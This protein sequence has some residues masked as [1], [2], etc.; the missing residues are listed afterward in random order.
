M[1]DRRGTAGRVLGFAIAMTSLGSLAGGQICQSWARTWGGSGDEWTFGL[2]IDSQGNFYLPGGTDSVGAGG[3]DALLLE[4]DSSGSFGW[5][6]TWGGSG[7]DDMQG[8]FFDSR[9]GGGFILSGSTR[10]FGASNEDVMLLKFD[11][12]GNLQWARTWDSLGNDHADAVFEDSAG[13]LYLAG[14]STGWSPFFQTEV[15]LMK[16]AAGS[17]PP[18]NPSVVTWGASSG[19]A[20]INDGCVWVDGSSGIEYVYV[21]GNLW[22]PGNDYDVLLQKYDASLNL[23]WSRSW[24]GSLDDDCWGI[25]VDGTGD[26]YV[27]GTTSSYS[28]G[29]EDALLLRWDA[30]GNLLSG[31][32]WGGP[33]DDGTGAIF[34]SGGY[35]YLSAKT[36]S[37]DPGYSDGLFLKYDPATARFLW[38]KTWGGTGQDDG[39]GLLPWNGSFWGVGFTGIHPGF[40]RDCIGTVTSIDPA[41]GVSSQSGPSIP[42]VGIEAS[43]NGITTAPPDSS[44]S[45]AEALLLAFSVCGSDPP[46]LGYCFGDPGLGTPCPCSNDNDESVPGSGCA[47]GVF[48]SGAHLSGSGAASVTADTVVLTTSGLQPSNTGLYFQANNAVNGGHGNPFGDGLRCAGGGLIR[49]QIRTSN[50]AGTSS[51]TIAIGVTG[52]VSAGDT[53]R[54]Q[55]WYRDTS[56]SQPCGV[57]VNDFNLSN[58][59]EITWLP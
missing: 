19:A 17:L 34:L 1:R 38:S 12:A 33:G 36:W 40:L 6:R 18:Q 43:P 7:D 27:T 28:A 21:G 15:L 37:F 55:C 45:S 39:A 32:A 48:A 50:P 13:N 44:G 51:T 11:L 24:G 23:L 35:I 41:V 14:G 5:A 57:G 47:N 53:K 46:G 49:L 4:Y 58:G 31:T 54:Y 42:R 25:A 26:V 52:G 29:Q 30:Q 2:G 16:Y 3:V 20:S 8:S 9:P 56:G 22:S 10:S 59:Y